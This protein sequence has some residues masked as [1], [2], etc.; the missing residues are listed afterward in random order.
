MICD[1]CKF[2]LVNQSNA[3]CLKFLG[4]AR[5]KE[6]EYIQQV[7]ETNNCETYKEKS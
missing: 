6:L 1:A 2:Q 7:K 4:H 3:N 5:Q